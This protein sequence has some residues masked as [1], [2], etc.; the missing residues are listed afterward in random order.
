MVPVAELPAH[1]DLVV[2]CATAAALPEIARAALDAGKILVPV[3]VGGFAAHPEI[4][5]WVERGGRVRVATG[6]LPGLDAIRTAA[7]DEIRS[8]RLIS[9]IRPESLVHEDHVRRLGFDFKNPPAEA[10]KVFE[11]TA[12]EAALAFPRHFNVAVT[13][14]LAGIGLDRTLVTMYADPAV[15]G[16]VHLI[17]VDA[18]NF[19][20]RLE[21]RNRPSATNPRTSRAV[22]PSVLAALRALISP[23]Q[24]GS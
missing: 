20:L 4:L 10:Q 2:E 22:A 12:R 8:V 19:Q 6:A 21:S 24:V 5:G 23:V 13:V 18:E 16:T 3:S 1:A 15:A 14:S 11:G 7:E 9:R 17:E